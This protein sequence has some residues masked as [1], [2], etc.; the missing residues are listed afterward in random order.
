MGA[1]DVGERRAGAGE[2]RG[3]RAGCCPAQALCHGCNTLFLARVGVGVAVGVGDGDGDCDGG[4]GGDGGGGCCC[5]CCC[6]CR[7]RCRCQRCCCCGQE[8]FLRTVHA[9][10]THAVETASR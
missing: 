7:C 1:G 5:C 2:G 3:A 8:S 9:C 6:C 4:G 10:F